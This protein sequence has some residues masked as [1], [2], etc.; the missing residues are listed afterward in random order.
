[1]SQLR[2]DA[3][4]GGRV[5]SLHRGRLDLARRRTE[6]LAAARANQPWTGET[7]RSMALLLGFCPDCD[8]ELFNDAPHADDCPRNA[9]ADRGR[10]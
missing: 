9:L 3:G 7:R 10:L 1:M 8:A 6:R 2:L 5:V 4:A